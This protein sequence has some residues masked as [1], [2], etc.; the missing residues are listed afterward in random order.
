MFL[1]YCSYYC[2]RIILFYQV[3]VLKVSL[4]LY[5]KT[6]AIM[7]HNMNASSVK[8]SDTEKCLI[9]GNIYSNLYNEIILS[10][11]Y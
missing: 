3:Y 5:S 8:F 11:T 10:G 4:I 2:L 9:F 7:K 1:N 6:F